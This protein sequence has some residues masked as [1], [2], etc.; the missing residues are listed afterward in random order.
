MCSLFQN[1][2]NQ[3]KQKIN[4]Q[5]SETVSVFSATSSK[6]GDLKKEIE[7]QGIPVQTSSMKTFYPEEYFKRVGYQPL[8]EQYSNSSAVVTAKIR[9]DALG[10]RVRERFN[11]ELNYD[12]TATKS[13]KL[14]PYVL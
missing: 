11:E 13:Q 2:L 14:T 5:R 10:Q 6:R 9:T 1:P 3:K 12:N 8:H 4:A 7:Q